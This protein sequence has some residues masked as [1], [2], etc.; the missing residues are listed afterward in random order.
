MRHHQEKFERLIADIYR[1][2]HPGCSVVHVG[3]SG[4]RG[5]DVYGVINGGDHA[6]IQVR[7]RKNTEGSEGQEVV[8]NLIGASF[9]LPSRKDMKKANLLFILLK[10][11]HFWRGARCQ[12]FVKA[13][14]VASRTDCV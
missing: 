5:A 13:Q 4:D 8:R 1:D 14:D 7:R 2:F 6:L 10:K 9:N 3:R 11:I 12:F